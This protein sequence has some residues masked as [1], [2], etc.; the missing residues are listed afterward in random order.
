MRRVF[1]TWVLSLGMAAL[2][3]CSSAPS[4]KTDV[5]APVLTA[6]DSAV[7]KKAVEAKA[8]KPKVEVDL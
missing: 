3:A 1:F 2:C 4:K 6:A 7:I 8:E 5:D